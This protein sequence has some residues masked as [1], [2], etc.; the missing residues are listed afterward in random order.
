MYA[1]RIVETAPVGALFAHP[2]HRYTQALIETMP[3]S[4]PPGLRLPSIPGMVPPPGKRGAGCTFAPRCHGLLEDC[5]LVRPRLETM[6][7]HRVACWNP[8]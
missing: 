7:S 5:V 1:G 8:A 6:G 2:R 4:N 3:A